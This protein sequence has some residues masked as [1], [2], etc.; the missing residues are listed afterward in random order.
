K[1]KPTKHGYFFNRLADEMTK[2]LREEGHSVLIEGRELVDG[3]YADLCNLVPQSRRIGWPQSGNFLSEVSL[4]AQMTV[5]DTEA[6]LF[7]ATAAPD[8]EVS[9]PARKDTADSN[10]IFDLDAIDHPVWVSRVELLETG[11]DGLMRG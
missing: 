6:L 3:T 2:T 11:R 10:D 9:L 1:G 4:P 7:E 8:S 5:P